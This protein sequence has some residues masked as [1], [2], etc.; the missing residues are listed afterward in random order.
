[1]LT[2]SPLHA[3]SMRAERLRSTPWLEVIR[4]AWLVL[5]GCALI[6][7]VLPRQLAHALAP[8]VAVAPLLLLVAKESSARPYRRARI[9]LTART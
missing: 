8:M 4:N 2:I 5:M 1:M 9:W 6:Q 3:L 7:L